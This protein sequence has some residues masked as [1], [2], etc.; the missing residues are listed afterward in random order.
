MARHRLDVVIAGAGPAGLSAAGHAQANG[1]SYVLL[2]KTDHLADTVFSYQ[3]RKHVMSEPGLIPLRGP[4]AFEAGT[5]ESI[6]DGWNRFATQGRLNVCYSQPV[7]GIVSRDGGFLVNTPTD[8]Y[9]A[10]KVILSIG[11]QGNPR[12]LGAPGEDLPHI[13]SRLIDPDAFADQDIVVVGGGD[14]AIEVAVALCE[15]NR[16]SMVVR[17]PEFIRVKE[18]LEREVLGRERAGQMK[19]FYNSAVKRVEPGSI[20]LKTPDRDVV[21][22]AAHVI[23]KIGTQPPRAFLETL[24]VR[25]PSAD[26]EAQPVL[27][28]YYES[29]VPGLFLI[30][31]VSG[32]PLIKLGINQGYEVIEHLLGR[33]VEPADEDLLK[34]KLPFL[35]GTARERIRRA[36]NGVP[37]LAAADDESL[38]EVFLAATVRSCR[39]GEVIFRQNDYTDSFLAILDGPVDIS[40][41]ADDGAARRVATLSAGSFFGEMSLISGRRRSATATS[42]GETRLLEIPRKPMLKLVYTSPAV[43]EI[44]NRTY[45]IRAF[46]S[47]LFP[48]ATD[49][50]LRDL[51]MT[52]VAQKLEKNTA[53]F[54]EGEPGDAFYLI[55]SG[56][57]KIAKASG[58]KELVL[59]YLPAGQYFGEMALLSGEPRSATVTAIFP[60]ELIRLGK[61]DFL[62]FLEARR[63]LKERI[64]REAERRRLAT[65]EA[66]AGT[67]GGGV[68]GE[69]I[70]EEV[71]IGTD[72]LLID[73]HRCVRCNNCVK[74]CEGVHEDG[75]ARLSLTGTTFYN[76]LVP[77]SCRHCEN[78]LCMTDCPP[79]AIARDPRGEVYIKNNCIGC[80][81][82]AKN[83]PYGN[84]FMVHPKAQHGILGWLKALWPGAGEESGRSVA[85]KCDLC[86][87]I[88]GGPA[89]VRSCPTGAAIRLKPE[90]SRRQI[91]RLVARGS[92]A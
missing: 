61:D 58:V 71:V 12:K 29:S 77:N 20:E 74:A 83:C 3:K 53:V 57:V 68:L 5:R 14:A 2:E 10:G 35:R 47:Y 27:N 92:G 32:R 79:D 55:R 33:P 81:N 24:G 91:E 17:T 62:R 51:A 40:V 25:F 4:L 1:V 9:E 36:A 16:V 45:L 75:Q 7:T 72:V 69:L 64:A 73:E 86:R 38:R 46:Q 30:G 50:E 34:A 31:A 28:Q 6:L 66:Q 42:V 22:P 88:A 67:E 26:R 78:P 44:L 49:N 21:V 54:R 87:D 60:T 82:C 84:I 41:A 37:I 80:G 43:S 8:E 89:C 48:Q 18:A 11:T 52:A 63:E 13:T 90:E 85:V 76:L 19:I 39:H 56:M 65:L 70:R 15:K 23:L 59:A